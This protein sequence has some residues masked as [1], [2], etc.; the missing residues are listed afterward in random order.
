M[1]QIRESLGIIAGLLSFFAYIPYIIDIIKGKTKPS[2]SSWWIWS[3][4]GLIILISYHSVGAQNTIWIPLVF[5]ICPLF[6]AILTIKHG[7]G[8]SLNLLDKICLIG[9]LAGVILWFFLHSAYLALII[10]I[11]VDCLGYITT[12]RKTLKNPSSE[13]KIT[14]ILFLFGSILNVFA[15]EKFGFSIAFYPVY[16]LVM[17]IIVV[18]ILVYY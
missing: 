8:H 14:W 11:A 10:N 17:D 4:V 9:A 3:L 6:I 15:I 12:I 13:S 16:M 1:I 18:G 7:E 2:R 5:F